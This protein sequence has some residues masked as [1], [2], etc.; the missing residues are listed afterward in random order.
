MV[1]AE[2]TPQIPPIATPYTI[3]SAKNVPKFGAIAEAS[4][5]SEK[6]TMLATRTGLRPNRSAREP[7]TSAPTGRRSRVKVM[8]RVAVTMVTPN[9]LAMDESANTRTKKSNA[10]SVQLP[11][12]AN[13]V[14]RCAGV[15]ASLV[16][17]EAEIDP[18]MGA[19]P[20]F[21]SVPSPSRTL[22]GILPPTA[23]NAVV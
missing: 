12:P 16:G 17:A 20:S 23:G 2:A 15:H 4:S 8:A 10:S 19:W 5:M 7:K 6:T 13:S 21:C 22:H 14:R 1:R 18:D 3:R 11:A 9:S